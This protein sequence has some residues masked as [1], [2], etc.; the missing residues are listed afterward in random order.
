MNEMAF[1]DFILVLSQL[2]LKA[3]SVCLFVGLNEGLR[4]RYTFYRL[5]FGIQ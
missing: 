3:E 5:N 1:N 2:L 4:S